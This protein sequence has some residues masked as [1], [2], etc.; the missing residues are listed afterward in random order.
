MPDVP[1]TQRKRSQF[2]RLEQLHQLAKHLVEEFRSD[3]VEEIER[4]ILNTGMPRRYLVRV[5]DVCSAQLDE[6]SAARQEPQR[7]I[8]EFFFQ[9]IEYDVHTPPRRLPQ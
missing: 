3:V 7:C 2:G 9:A 6:S 5:S 4:V 1:R 8:D